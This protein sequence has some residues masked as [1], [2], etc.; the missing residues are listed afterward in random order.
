[1]KIETLKIFCDIIRFNS[2]SK[3]ATENNITQSMASQAIN[4]L[5][6]HFQTTLIDRS[7]R[8]WQITPEGELCYEQSQELLKLYTKLENKL[9]LLHKKH[10]T[11]VRIATIYSAGLVYMRPLIDAYKTNNSN[12]KTQVEY[13][14]PNEVY[15]AI[16]EN[17]TDIGIVSSSKGNYR[18]IEF[19]P[20][21]EEEMVVAV[22][23]DH[24]FAKQQKISVKDLQKSALINFDPELSIR[25]SIRKYFKLHN[26][27]VKTEMHF[28][29]VESIK[30]AVEIS[31]GFA[32]L[33]KPCLKREIKSGT[34]VIIPV[35]E[36]T[37]NRELFIIHRKTK[38]LLPSVKQ[39]INLM[40]QMQK[41]D[42]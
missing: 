32:L 25:R 18:D 21:L 39:L 5:E 10:T 34:L 30:R 22:A 1:M 4:R 14:H 16:S 24:P 12:T 36:R 3:G 6:K 7:H 37:F 23:P 9:R 11:T 13:F 19:I 28:D 29:N 2:F 8:P 42:F 33:P 26:L 20:W 38:Q 27:Q 35:Q 31:T 15:S 40:Q 17:K 41:Q